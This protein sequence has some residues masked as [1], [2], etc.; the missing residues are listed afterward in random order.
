MMK[1]LFLTILALLPA[2]AAAQRDTPGI[3][4]RSSAFD[5]E[6][7]RAV[8]EFHTASSA[9]MLYRSEQS[10]SQLSLRFNL[11]REQEALLQP[12]GDGAFDGGFY[13][14]SYQR[15]S[16]RSA[17]WADA[18][19]VR[20][21]RRNVC[22]NSTA[23]YLLL[24]PCVTADSVG[25]NLSTEEYAF[26]GGYVRR[27]GRFDLAIRGE[28]RAGQEYR[29]VDPRPHN[30]VSDFTVRLGVGMQFP[31][32]VLG[33]DLQGRLYKQDQDIDFFYP[34]GASS[35]ELYM[36]GLGS[37][38]ARYSLTETSFDIGYDGKGCLLAVQLM[39]RYAKGWYA[40][41]AFESLTTER[42]NKP[43]NTV[44][45][46]RLETRQATFAAAYRSGRW[47][48]RAGGGY[49]LRRSIE[50]VAD[51]T[52]HSVIVDEQAMYRNR[53]WRADAEA[54]VEWRGGTVNYRLSPR[55]EW[56]QSTAAYVYPAR[57][58]R[59]AQFCGAVRGSAEWLR[60]Q[61]RVKATAGIGCYVSPDEEVSLSGI[62]EN[63]S[64]YLT[65]TAA[66]LS[67]R[68]VAPEVSL[69]AERRLS[70]NLACFAETGWRPRFY[71]GGLSEHLLTA[72]FGILF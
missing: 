32:Y 12:L 39:P 23:D 58:M 36:T 64:Q 31:Q 9:A 57:R 14:E 59:L 11:R 17:A 19:Y 53:I 55:A 21:S 10:L 49:E 47:S 34:P 54:T 33:L 68:A 42:L 38:Y 60:P 70:R 48:L 44:P 24:Y 71:S 8:A 20:G 29:Q 45:V 67:G 35:S 46:T 56:R 7:E 51:R 52:G 61:W 37:H 4:E 65:Y 2:A 6:S 15:L 30:V 18:R 62:Q 50:M 63:I 66:R 26:G 13:A 16:E 5:A 25:G 43:N 22:W 40:R 72:A 28:Y 69:R 1:A 27:V 41:A 3:L